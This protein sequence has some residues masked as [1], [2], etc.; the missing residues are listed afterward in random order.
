L[1]IVESSSESV[2]LSE[3]KES[4]LSEIFQ[5][6]NQDFEMVEQSELELLRKENED[7]KQKLLS[8]ES[9]NT[10]LRQRNTDSESKYFRYKNVSKNS[11][12]FRKTTGISEEKFEELLEYITPGEDS[13]NISYLV[14]TE[15]N[16]YA[17][18]LSHAIKA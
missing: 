12:L 18:R 13:C 9:I 11:E 5:Q 16:V 8:L 17:R 15:I 1:P 3:T 6:D 10:D 4:G 7:L 2:I 14:M